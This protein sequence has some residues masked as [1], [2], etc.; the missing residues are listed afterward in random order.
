MELS[1]LEFATRLGV[2][3]QTYRTWD[4]GRRT[5]PRL[6]VSKA[7]RLQETAGGLLPMQLLADEYG[8]HV[9]TLR[10]AAHDGRLQA[11]FSIR[12]AFGKLVAFASRDAVET[13]KRRYY[14][15]TTQ[16]NRP[17]K[18]TACTLLSKRR[19]LKRDGAVPSADQTDG[20]EEDDD[21]RQ[22][23][24]SSRGSN[25]QST[26]QAS[27][28]L[29]GEVHGGLYSLKCCESDVR[30]SGRSGGS[31]SQVCCTVEFT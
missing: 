30:D 6:I 10:K 17:P 4:S 2:A 29:C 28:S 15:Q 27:R 20:P 23:E 9:R 14:R 19:V 3:E 13:F 16:W 26:A 7:K 21:R 5:P 18:P 25:P 22:H 24:R 8:I 1:Q 11:T 31:V 12:L